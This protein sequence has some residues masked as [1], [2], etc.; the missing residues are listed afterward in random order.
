LRVFG[1]TGFLLSFS[2][3]SRILAFEVPFV[4][5]VVIVVVVRYGPKTLRVFVVFAFLHQ[6][7]HRYEVFLDLRGRHRRRL[8]YRRR[9][10]KGSRVLSERFAVRESAFP[11]RS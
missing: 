9:R 7:G 5:S 10:R 8:G 4:F 1:T 11:V 3:S 6:E 2:L